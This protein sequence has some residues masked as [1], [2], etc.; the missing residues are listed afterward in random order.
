MCSQVALGL[1]A[2]R[3]ANEKWLRVREKVVRAGRQVPVGPRIAE[4]TY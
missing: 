3:K 1:L 4:V 2:K